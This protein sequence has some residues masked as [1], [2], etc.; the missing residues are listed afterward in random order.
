MKH[1]IEQLQEMERILN[2]NS[3]NFKA[4]FITRYFDEIGVLEDIIID[5]KSDLKVFEE[6]YVEPIDDYNEDETDEHRA[7]SF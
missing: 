7:L 5:L 2:L 1:Y 3:N 6:D 4:E